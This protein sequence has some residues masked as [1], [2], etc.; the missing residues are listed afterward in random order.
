MGQVEH[1]PVVDIEVEDIVDNHVVEE[2]HKSP[3]HLKYRSDE[4]NLMGIFLV[5]QWVHGLSTNLQLVR[6]EG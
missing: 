6:Y 2:I 5:V 1:T 4:R 3:Y